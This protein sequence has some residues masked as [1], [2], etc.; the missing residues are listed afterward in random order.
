[1]Y[2][3]ISTELYCFSF[4]QAIML[5]LITALGAVSGTIMS[6]LA[7]GVGMFPFCILSIHVLILIPFSFKLHWL[8]IS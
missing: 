4:V 7:E 8:L 5:Q 3:L 2:V 6:L 1:M